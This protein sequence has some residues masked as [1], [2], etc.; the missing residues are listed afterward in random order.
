ML[1]IGNLTSRAPRPR[2]S[3]AHVI[4]TPAAPRTDRAEAHVTLVDRA[5]QRGTGRTW[6]GNDARATHGVVGQDAAPGSRL[7]AGRRT[8]WRDGEPGPGADRFGGVG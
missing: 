1:K 8:G 7:G 2:E 3:D 4:V 5:G 6:R